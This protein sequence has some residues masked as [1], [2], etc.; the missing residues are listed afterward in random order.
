[1]KVTCKKQIVHE[2]SMKIKYFFYFF[3]ELF[4]FLYSHIKIIEIFFFLVTN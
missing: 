1:M 4:I 3:L 2:D